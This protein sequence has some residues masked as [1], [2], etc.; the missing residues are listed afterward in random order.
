MLLGAVAMLVGCAPI[1][2]VV[3]K[4]F[5]DNQN[6]IL[7]EPV[8]YRIGRSDAVVRVPKGFVTDFASVPRPLCGLLT[9]HDLYSKAAVVHDYLY[10]TQQCTREQADNILL[11]AMKE[12]GVGRADQWMVHRAVRAFGQA[13][14][15]ANAQERAAGLP[16][17]LPSTEVNIDAEAIWT[18]DFRRRLRDERNVSIDALPPGPPSYCAAGDTVDLPRRVATK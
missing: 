5:A 3:V 18:A 10:W 9:P 11:L 14:W 13:A 15:Q 4:P 2:P 16:R 7:M 17:V 8:E 1:R 12:S 6:W